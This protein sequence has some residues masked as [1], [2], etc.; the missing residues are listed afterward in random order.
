MSALNLATAIQRTTQACGYRDEG[1]LESL[2]LSSVEPSYCRPLKSK[3]GTL[4]FIYFFNSAPKLIASSPHSCHVADKAD[5]RNALMQAGKLAEAEVLYRKALSAIWAP[6]RQRKDAAAVALGVAVDLNLAL[7][8]LKLERWDAARRSASRALE[9]E[10]ENPKGLYRRGLA[11]ARLDLLDAAHDDLSKA[12][13]QLVASSIYPLY[14]P[15][16]V[17][18]IPQQI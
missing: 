15:P 11:S 4:V 7:C 10:P 5:P 17:I 6:Y 9:A 1:F 8:Y 14:G 12:S 13:N 16:Y 3:C 2:L 18:N